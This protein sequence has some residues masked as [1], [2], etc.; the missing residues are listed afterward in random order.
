MFPPPC[1]IFLSVW[2]FCQYTDTLQ[3]ISFYN[4][5]TTPPPFTPPSIIVSFFHFTATPFSYLSPLMVSM[6]PYYLH[7]PFLSPWLHWLA[8]VKVA[9]S[10]ID[11]S[12]GQFSEFIFIHLSSPFNS[13]SLSLLIEN[14]SFLWLWW[15]HTLLFHWWPLFNVFLQLLLLLLSEC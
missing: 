15:Y 7:N 6:P 1:L 12:S 8:V 5:M 2:S 14:L 3:C 11:Y 13:A 10:S 9:K 4:K